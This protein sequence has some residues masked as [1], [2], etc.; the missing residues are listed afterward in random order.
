MKVLR[1]HKEKSCK[2]KFAW[3][4]KCESS[5]YRIQEVTGKHGRLLFHLIPAGGFSF[6][7]ASW[8]QC[9]ISRRCGEFSQE[10]IHPKNLQIKKGPCSRLA[11]KWETTSQRKVKR[12]CRMRNL[13]RT[14]TFLKGKWQQKWQISESLR[15]STEVEKH[16]IEPSSSETTFKVISQNPLGVPPKGEILVPDYC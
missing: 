3:D 14:V 5:N 7:S 12:W 8:P 11:V 13:Q 9:K 15:Q 1:K 6:S 2:V 4:L 16:R 10:S